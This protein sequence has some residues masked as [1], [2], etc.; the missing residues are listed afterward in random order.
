MRG[1]QGRAYVVRL[2]P[3]LRAGALAL[4]KVAR[5]HSGRKRFAR[6]KA[7]RHGTVTIQKVCKSL[8]TDMCMEC[9]LTIHVPSHMQ[10]CI[11]RLVQLIEMLC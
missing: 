7:I 5:G 1:V 10:R 9:A 3:L 6:I 2:R 11:R 4:Q 8:H